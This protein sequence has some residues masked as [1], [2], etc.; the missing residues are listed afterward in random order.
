MPPSPLNESK[1]LL[2]NLHY[3]IDTLLNYLSIGRVFFILRLR[4]KRSLIY[5]IVAV[6]FTPHGT[7]LQILT[8]HSH[9][10]ENLKAL[11]DEHEVEIGKIRTKMT[12]DGNKV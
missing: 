9:Q 12:G 5:R 10:E 8:C 4:T 7:S 1:V 2:L 6:V 3:K 11:F